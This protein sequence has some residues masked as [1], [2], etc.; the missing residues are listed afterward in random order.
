MEY[1]QAPFSQEQIDKINKYQES[2]QSNVLTC[3]G[4]IHIPK[5]GILE[6]NR[7]LCDNNGI[8]VADKEGLVCPC[9]NCTEEWVYKYMTE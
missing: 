4:K 2:G 3:I 8:L 6:R 9:G 1:V 7:E 5:K